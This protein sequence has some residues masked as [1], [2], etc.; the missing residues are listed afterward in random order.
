[1]LEPF[2]QLQV[3]GRI[4]RYKISKLQL[5]KTEALNQFQEASAKLTQI[6][7]TDGQG[8]V[9]NKSTPTGAESK[10]KTD[11]L[12]WMVRSFAEPTKHGPSLDKH[13]RSCKKASQ[14]CTTVD[15]ILREPI[16]LMASDLAPPTALFQDRER[17]VR[18]VIEADGEILCEFTTELRNCIYD[19][20]TDS[21][22]D[23]TG[24]EYA[25]IEA[26][27]VKRGSKELKPG[28]QPQACNPLRAVGIKEGEMNKTSKD[29]LI[30]DG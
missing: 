13:E 21:V 11:P 20:C 5:A 12:A 7:S 29:S 15:L 26:N 22:S 9:S 27:A 3:E 1:M 17:S 19:D 2:V 8:V 23:P 10:A 28:S 30:N 6:C 25:K 16:P 24:N 18:S 14:W 4:A